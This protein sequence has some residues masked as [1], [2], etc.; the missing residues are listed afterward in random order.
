[1]NPKVSIVI[2]VYNGANYLREAIDSAL[3]QTYE[4]I[5]VVV[6]NDGSKDNGATEEIALSYGDKIRYIA[7]ENGGVS[8]AL[9]RGI[10]EMT[11]EYFSWLSHDDLYTPDKIKNQIAHITEE[12]KD[13]IFMCGSAFVDKDAKPMQRKIRKFKDGYTPYNKLLLQMFSGCTISGCALLIPKK[14][15]DSFGIFSEEIKYMQD[16][17][18]WYRFLTNGVNFMCNMDEV[19]VLSRV[20]DNQTTVTGKHLGRNDADIVGANMVKCL[21]GMQN[22]DLYLLKHYMF[23]CCRNNSQKTR[24]LAYDASKEKGILNIKDKFKYRYM[25]VY[26]KIRPYLVRVYY[27]VFLKVRIK[28]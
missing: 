24:K 3:S 27:T 12:N 17:E 22:E 7:K 19:G 1:M 4:N 15:F 8:S 16:T 23:L 18:L 21:Y 10:A 14:H 11:G 2:P 9:N 25:T 20:H 26:G 13:C 28:K 5:E 6:V